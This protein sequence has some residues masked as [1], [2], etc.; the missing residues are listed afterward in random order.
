L[1]IAVIIQAELLFE[2]NPTGAC[3]SHFGA[4]TG[5]GVLTALPGWYRLGHCILFCLALVICTAN[6]QIIK[7]N[8]FFIFRA[9]NS[10]ITDKSYLLIYKLL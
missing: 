2:S 8:S 10:E 5:V 7:V 1:Y 3:K 6:T 9:I 4:D